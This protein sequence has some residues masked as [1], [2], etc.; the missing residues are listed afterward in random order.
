M[1]I[2]VLVDTQTFICLPPGSTLQ[3]DTGFGP[4]YF[5]RIIILL[6]IGKKN[7]T[8]GPIELFLSQQTAPKCVNPGQNRL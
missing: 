8:N 3:T 1:H 2:S 6:N 5:R 4:A 7:T